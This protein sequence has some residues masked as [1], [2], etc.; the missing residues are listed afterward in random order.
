MVDSDYVMVPGMHYGGSGNYQ[1]FS[2]QIVD[3]DTCYLEMFRANSSS[4]PVKEY[5]NT[6]GALYKMWCVWLGDQ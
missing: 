5:Y 6:G 4:A 3:E 2:S 1:V